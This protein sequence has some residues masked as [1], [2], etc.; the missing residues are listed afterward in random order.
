MHARHVAP[1]LTELATR[2]VHFSHFCEDDLYLVKWYCEPPPLAGEFVP[3]HEVWDIRWSLPVRRVYSWDWPPDQV[4]IDIDLSA[5]GP[6]SLMVPL[7]ARAAESRLRY[8]RPVLRAAIQGKLEDGYL[9]GLA[10]TM[11]GRLSRD[12]MDAV[13]ANYWLPAPSRGSPGRTGRRRPAAGRT[14]SSG[15]SRPPGSSGCRTGR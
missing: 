7:P 10:E 6:G 1:R 11:A 12:E 15:S 9:N 4:V 14:G 3:R 2:A 5:S 8:A 13:A